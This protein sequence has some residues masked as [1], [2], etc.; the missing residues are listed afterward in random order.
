MPDAGI[1]A[2]LGE[3]SRNPRTFATPMPAICGAHSAGFQLD[4]HEGDTLHGLGA[5]TSGEQASLAAATARGTA[6]RG[7]PADA[8]TATPPASA[9]ATTTTA[10]RARRTRTR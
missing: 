5:A 1:E 4:P 8:G 7:A 10:V 6:L 3:S 9:T 2:R